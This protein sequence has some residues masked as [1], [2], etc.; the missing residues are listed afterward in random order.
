M[1]KRRLGIDLT[2]AV[3]F[4][5]TGDIRMALAALIAASYGQIG[6]TVG[7]FPPDEEPPKT[8]QDEAAQS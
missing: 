7:L 8:D 6:L 2:K 4:A 1:G 5:T 3:P